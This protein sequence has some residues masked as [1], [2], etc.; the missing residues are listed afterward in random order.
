VPKPKLLVATR[1][2]HKTREFRELLGDA[3]ELE[4]LTAHSEIPETPETGGTFEENAT[5]KALAV[6]KHSP[7]LVIADDSGLEV[8]ALNGAPGV[9]SARYAADGANDQQNIDKLLGELRRVERNG[10]GNMRT[11]RFRCVIVLAQNGS[12]IRVLEGIVEGRIVDPARGSNGF[13]YDPIFQPLGY[14]ETFGELDAPRKNLISHR[15]RATQKLIES[16]ATG[17]NQ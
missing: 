10:N 3:F 15:A 13:G 17:K 7:A 6:S 12:V 4:D 11:A 2:S 14:E 9:Y 1:N 5:L 8:D 16:L